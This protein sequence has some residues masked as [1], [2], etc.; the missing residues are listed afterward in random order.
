MG[1]CGGGGE[2]AGVGGVGVAPTAVA[3]AGAAMLRPTRP[4]HQPTN[5]QQQQQTH[6]THHAAAAPAP[7]LTHAG[8]W[9]ACPPVRGLQSIGARPK[10]SRGRP[11]LLLAAGRAWPATRMCVARTAVAGW[12][13]AAH[14]RGRVAC[15]WRTVVLTARCG[16]AT[17]YA[18]VPG[19]PLRAAV[20]PGCVQTRARQTARG[21]EIGQRGVAEEVVRTAWC[22]AH[23]AVRGQCSRQCHSTLLCGGGECT[24]AACGMPFSGVRRAP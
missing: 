3:A 15:G 13:N 23:G 10:P 21:G 12:H 1:W 19:V 14:H 4:L 22:T 18:R 17:V 24:S 5:Q 2:R 6:I 20:V 8:E 16:T 9:V 11:L 7:T